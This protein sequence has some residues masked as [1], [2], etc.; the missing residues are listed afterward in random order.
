MPL[1]VVVSLNRLPSWQRQAHATGQKMES[2]IPYPVIQ[3]WGG[4]RN[5]DLGSQKPAI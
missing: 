1:G 2:K 5:I 4:K 3:R